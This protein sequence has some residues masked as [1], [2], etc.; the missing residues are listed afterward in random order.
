MSCISIPVETRYRQ[1]LANIFNIGTTLKI[2]DILRLVKVDRRYQ[3]NLEISTNIGRLLSISS[4]QIPILAD[5]G[6]STPS[7]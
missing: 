5:Y 6:H 4:S 3:D 2:I 1:Y 7:Q